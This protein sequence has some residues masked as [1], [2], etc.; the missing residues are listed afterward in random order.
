M[1]VIG[2]PKLSESA[3]AL[4]GV[5]EMLASG[6][7]A[8]VVVDVHR[9]WVNSVM[10]DK[11]RDHGTILAD[12]ILARLNRMTPEEKAEHRKRAEL[13]GPFQCI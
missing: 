4:P 8:S 11:E 5:R 13:Y 6:Y 1:S 12:V 9:D 2:F 3:K 7:P 10:L